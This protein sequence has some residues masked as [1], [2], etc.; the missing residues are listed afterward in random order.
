MKLTRL[1]SCTSNVTGFVSYECCA[2]SNNIY[3]QNNISWISD[4]NLIHING[5]CLTFD[6]PVSNGTSYKQARIFDKDSGRKWCYN[7]TTT[8]GHDYLIRGTFLHGINVR[9]SYS[10]DATFFV[11]VGTTSIAQ[12]NSSD[13]TSTVE[14]VFRATNHYVDFCLV[15]HKGSPY[16]SKLELRPLDDFAYLE[17]NSSVILKLVQRVDVGNTQEPIRYVNYFCNCC[18]LCR[19]ELSC[20]KR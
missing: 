4:N 9:N 5:S 18:D 17:G 14:A 10:P 6:P 16:I 15:K 19:W 11:S 7:L 8:K 1:I 12:V 13:D 2:P 20:M 3:L